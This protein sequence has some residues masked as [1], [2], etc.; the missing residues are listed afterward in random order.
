MKN[1]IG[2]S[3]EPD[4]VSWNDAG[5]WIALELTLNMESKHDKLS[6]YA[7]LDPRYL[8]D[9]GAQGISSK[10][11]IMSSRLDDFDDGPYCRILVNDVLKV[12]NEDRLANKT[13]RIEIK[14]AENTDLRRLP[15][16]PIS[17]LPESKGN[18]IR[19]GMVDQILQLFGP[20][21]EGITAKQV[22]DRALERLAD[23]V[24][25][26]R[27]NRLVKEVEEE[28]K[29]LATKQLASYLEVDKNGIYRAKPSLNMDHHAARLSVAGILKT[30]AGTPLT[31]R[32]PSIESYSGGERM[33]S[34]NT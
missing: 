23:K 19:R 15:T 13:L 24:R 26:E 3:G 32:V 25:V 17:M 8:A 16:I 22:V 10:P 29:S 30:W 20:G 34:T 11:D 6:L 2:E 1:K 33:D 18:E 21:S 4:L 31:F 14:N 27:K 12:F 7:N 28:L 5:D 9:Y